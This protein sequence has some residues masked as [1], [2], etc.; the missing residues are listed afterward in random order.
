MIDKKWENNELYKYIKSHIED[1]DKVDNIFNCLLPNMIKDFGED[2]ISM[3]KVIFIMPGKLYQYSIY[4]G[5]SYYPDIV[6][7]I[8]IY[9]VENACDDGFPMKKYEDL[10]NLNVQYSNAVSQKRLVREQHKALRIQKKLKSEQFRKSETRNEDY[11]EDL[12][13]NLDNIKKYLIKQYKD[14]TF[15]KPNEI[16]TNAKD[17][18]NYRIGSLVYNNPFRINSI[19]DESIYWI[20]LCDCGNYRV[21]QGGRINDYNCCERCSKPEHIYIGERYGH[22]E[23]IDQQYLLHGK[24]STT[25]K[26]KCKCDCGSVIILSPGDFNPIRVNCGRK[27]KYSIERRIEINKENGNHFNPMFYKDTNVGK[28]GRKSVNSNNSSGYL[29]VT[30]IESTGRYLAYITFQKKTEMLGTYKTPEEAYKVRLA[31]QNMLHAQ[32][33]Q[34]LD[35]N[36]FVKNNKYLLRLLNKVKN[37]VQDNIADMPK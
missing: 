12:K 15:L 6:Q 28:L 20:G 27:C 37:A 2:N 1:L 4:D 22:L 35:E 8:C 33:L 7:L 16:S 19:K 30:F 10:F 11:D 32:F 25:L 3:N 23:C 18:H 31:A 26:L 9:K 21:T 13:I 29:G 17:L 14:I 5:V 24:H 36:D 34:E